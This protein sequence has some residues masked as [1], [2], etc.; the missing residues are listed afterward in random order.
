V[1]GARKANAHLSWSSRWVQKLSNKN[2][3]TQS[4]E[5]RTNGK[6]DRQTDRQL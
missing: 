2:Y 3:G 5:R 4:N 6:T 1:T